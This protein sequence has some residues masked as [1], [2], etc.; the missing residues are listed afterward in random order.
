MKRVALFGLLIILLVTVAVASEP[1]KVFP[2]FFDW[3]V[4]ENEP[5]NNYPVLAIARV[6]DGDTFEAWI[7]IA[8]R[9]AYF[10]DVRVD[11]VDTPETDVAYKEEGTRVTAIVA[12]FLADAAEIRIRLTGYSFARWVCVVTIDGRDLA[13]L[14]K[15]NKLTKAD[16]CPDE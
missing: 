9:L 6:I 11:G 12:K 14:I 5:V 10:V 4:I 8:P 1:V 16:L 7:H 15:E 3:R 2:S 13:T